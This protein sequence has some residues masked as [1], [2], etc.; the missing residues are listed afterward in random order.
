MESGMKAGQEGQWTLS[1][2]RK[3]RFTENVMILGDEHPCLVFLWRS[4][5]C[6]AGLVRK[7]L[8]VMQETQ[9]SQVQSL[10]WEDSLEKETA[11][12]SNIL[13][14]KIPWTEEPGWLQSMGSVKSIQRVGHDWMPKHAK[15]IPV[16]FSSVALLCPTLCDPMNRSTP[17]L[18][19]HHQLPEFAQTHV[20]W[21][22]DAIQPSHPLSSPSPPAPNPSQH[23]GLFQ[24]VNSSHQVA[25]VLEFQLQHQ[26]F[27][28][29]FSTDFL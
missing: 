29:L 5:G 10:G 18:P 4:M 22:G 25:K 20:H 26:S 24:W 13:A 15:E 21:V 8:H 23:R 27:Q 17:G 19:V 28:W 2:N 12:H 9:E 16:Q 11:T 6:P 14:W 3:N 1:A 7:N